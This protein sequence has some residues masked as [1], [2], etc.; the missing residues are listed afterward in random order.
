M[1]SESNTFWFKGWLPNGV[2]G[3]FTIA[4]NPDTAFEQVMEFTN[5]L[6]AKGVTL[7]EPGLEPGQKRE[8]VSQVVI[9]RKEDGTLWADLYS[10]KAQ[11]E[12]RIARCYFDADKADVTET[13]QRY[14]GYSLTGQHKL[15]VG[16]NPVR[17]GK[18]A[19]A[20]AFL[21]TLPNPVNV[22][23]FQN[24]DYVEPPAGQ[25]PKMAKWKVSHFEPLSQSTPPP[26]APT[27]AQPTGNPFAVDPALATTVV[28]QEGKNNN[29]YLA[30]LNAQNKPLGVSTTRQVFTD[31]GYDTNS[32]TGV[33]TRIPLTPPARIT[34]EA[35]DNAVTVIAVTKAA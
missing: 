33:G 22:V 35:K 9:G 32:W 24:P 34:V 14:S 25:M 19:D 28:I 11:L 12:N 3:S 15:W 1:Q 27:A 21:V 13:F 10:P 29:R 30:V 16:E 20:D 7:H 23:I 17:R 6:L 5:T 18:K 31:A 26:A 4:I 2:P 8:A